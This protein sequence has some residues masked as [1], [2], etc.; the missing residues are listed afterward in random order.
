MKSAG[1]VNT[2]KVF[3]LDFLIHII[4]QRNKKDQGCSKILFPATAFLYT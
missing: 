3:P 1:F 4:R 2:V